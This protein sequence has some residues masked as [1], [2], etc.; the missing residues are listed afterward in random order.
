MKGAEKLI[1]AQLVEK[2]SVFYGPDD[3]LPFS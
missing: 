1:V 3:P 2:F